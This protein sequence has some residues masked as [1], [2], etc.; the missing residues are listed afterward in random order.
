MIYGVPII[1]IFQGESLPSIKVK[2]KISSQHVEINAAELCGYE[3]HV[4]VALIEESNAIVPQCDSTN[5]RGT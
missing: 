3:K 2:V 5:C 1:V 4:I